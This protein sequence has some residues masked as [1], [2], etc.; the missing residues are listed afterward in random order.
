MVHGRRRKG[1]QPAWRV[2]FSV[3]ELAGGPEWSR[4]FWLQRSCQAQIEHA[5]RQPSPHSFSPLLC[6]EKVPMALAT[7]C[8]PCSISDSSVAILLLL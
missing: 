8:P 1:Y 2:R 3:A 5:G 4:D 7:S 6:M